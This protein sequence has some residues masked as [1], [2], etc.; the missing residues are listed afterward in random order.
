MVNSTIDVRLM[1]TYRGVF[2][3]KVVW[4]TGAA[5][6]LVWVGSNNLTRDGLL[7]NIEFAA[8]IKARAVPDGLERW[9]DAVA[10]G[11]VPA[12]PDV[13]KSYRT[14]R[15]TFENRRAS[16]KAITFT[17]SR[18]QE[19]EK[20]EALKADLLKGDLVIEIM[21]QETRG[22]NQIQL[23][24]EAAGDFFGLR[25]VGDQKTVTLRPLDGS[26]SR[27]LVITVFQNNTV[28]LSINELEYRDRPCVMVFRK[29][30]GGSLIEFEIVPESI[31]PTRYRS[32]LAAC[33]R[34]TRD[35]SRR[36]TIK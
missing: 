3:P 16:A 34:Q 35:G 28:R 13:L 9:A 27:Q 29:R 8:L 21:P 12:T 23:P 1:K 24:K 10:S 33:H 25:D 14:E 30:R 6:H 15:D 20:K 32:L 4:L 18:K 7:H 31:Y 36:W 11:S 26:D 22:G 2:H 5:N 19:P 17:W